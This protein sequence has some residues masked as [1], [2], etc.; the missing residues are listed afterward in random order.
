MNF[1][2]RLGH[3]IQRLSEGHTPEADRSAK[4]GGVGLPRKIPLSEGLNRQVTSL[5]GEVDSYTRHLSLS[6]GGFECP[7]QGPLIVY[8]V[9]NGF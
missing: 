1:P 4:S 6:I 8:R 9:V 7:D 5:V 2:V 3:P